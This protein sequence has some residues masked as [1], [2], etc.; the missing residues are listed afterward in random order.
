M[1]K[2]CLLSLVLMAL[3]V[4]MIGGCSQISW[5]NNNQGTSQIDPE[6][7]RFFVRIASR[8]AL[9]EAN[10][11]AEDVGIVRTY[12]IAVK[13]FLSGVEGEPDFVN[14]RNLI[15]SYLP[16]EYWLYGMTIID[17]IERYISSLHIDFDEN[18][19]LVISLIA[20]AIDGAIDAVDEIALECRGTSC[21][22]LSK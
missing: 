2:N 21:P 16:S 3:L 13:D 9:N 6:D 22:I 14:A 4:P 5:G 20:A 11:P 1:K 12:L 18:Q 17:V 8:I 7:I 15:R 19:K 10:V